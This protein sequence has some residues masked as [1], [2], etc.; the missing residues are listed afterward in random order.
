MPKKKKKEKKENWSQCSG[1][2]APKRKQCVMAVFSEQRAEKTAQHAGILEDVCGKGACEVSV[3][4][5]RDEFGFV[6]GERC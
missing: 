1:I 6:R 4:E 2:L 3:T 5:K